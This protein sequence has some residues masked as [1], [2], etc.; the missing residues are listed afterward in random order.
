MNIIINVTAIERVEEESQ[1]L[2]SEQNSEN[3]FYDN[4]NTW[5]NKKSNGSYQNNIFNSN[6]NSKNKNEKKILCNS[7]K[8]QY[9]GQI[10][11]TENDNLKFSK[12]HRNMPDEEICSEKKKFLSTEEISLK[13]G[14]VVSV[15]M[16]K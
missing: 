5:K 7:M 16:S 3:E 12:N 10:N 15:E 4:S 9:K 1:S 14:K 8:S 13:S 2:L 6:P 11:E